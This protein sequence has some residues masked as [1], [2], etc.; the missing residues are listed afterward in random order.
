[1]SFTKEQILEMPM[2]VFMRDVMERKNWGTEPNPNKYVYP[3]MIEVMS[4][5]FPEARL[6]KH[7]NF[8]RV[9]LGKVLKTLEL[10]GIPVKSPFPGLDENTTRYLIE[11]GYF[12]KDALINAIKNGSLKPS[13]HGGPMNFGSVK[14]AVACA[15]A[16]VTGRYLTKP[17]YFENCPHCGNPIRIVIY[18]HEK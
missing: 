18:S 12:D 10:Y 14:Y 1:M 17:K 6:L 3:K 2:D 16:G 15:Y 8:G 9:T 7:R 5:E 11:F 4:S 13:Q